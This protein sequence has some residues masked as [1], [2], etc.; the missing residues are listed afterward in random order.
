M[1]YHLDSIL[2][3][4]N[5]DN[6]MSANRLLAHAIGLCETIIYS[7]L[8]SKYTY[9]INKGMIDEGGWFFSTVDDL[10]ES[11]TY[12]EKPQ[13]TAIKHLIENNLI[14]CKVKGIPAKRYFR[15]SD[16]VQK[17][18]SLIDKG[19]EIAKKLKERSSKS[20]IKSNVEIISGNKSVEQV[21]PEQQNKELL[22]GGTSS[23]QM[24]EL[25]TPER[26]NKELPKGGVKPNINKPN[27]INLISNQSINP[28]EENK[29]GEKIDRKKE[30]AKK[31]MSYSEM[32]RNIGSIWCNNPYIQDEEAF[33]MNDVTERKT[34]SCKIP[35]SFIENPNAL[36]S[37]LKFLLAYSYR[38]EPDNHYNN[39]TRP[40]DEKKRSKRFADRTIESLIEIITSEEF[41]HQGKLINPETV[42]DKINEVNQ[43]CDLYSWM[44]EWECEW[45]DIM[46]ERD[47]I[48]NQNAYFKACVWSSLRDYLDK[49]DNISMYYSNLL[50]A[51]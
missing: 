19:V 7:A 50:L 3:L 17:L 36:K 37:A 13:R 33:R 2:Q 44:Y 20:K 11:T 41:K 25:D 10:Q 26:Q 47:N 35:Y 28:Q 51:R 31:E 22:N 15:I 40:L 24:A 1:S 32:L 9:Y 4:L 14:E 39:D 18:K 27:I 8:I 46:T 6:T 16:N 12:G 23:S 34:S 38:I 49:S 30:K 42:I 43:D 29:Q 45:Q 5:P 21:A 48:K